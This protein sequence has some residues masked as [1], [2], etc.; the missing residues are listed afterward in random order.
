MSSLWLPTQAKNAG[1]KVRVICCTTGAGDLLDD[2]R[3]GFALT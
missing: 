2:F 1:S 3:D